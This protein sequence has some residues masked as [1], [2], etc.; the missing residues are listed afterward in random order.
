MLGRFLE[1]SI[2]TPDIRASLEF[3]AKLGFSQAEVGEAWPHPYAVVTDGRICTRS[4]PATTSQRR[5]D[6]RQTGSARTFLASSNA[7]HRFRDFAVSATTYST[8][9]VVARSF[10]PSDPAG[11]GAHLLPAKRPRRPNLAVR[12]FPR[13]RVA[14]A[15]VSRRRRTSGRISASSAW[16]SPAR[17]CRTSRCTS[18]TIDIGLYD[19]LDL[20]RPMLLFEA[21]RRPPASKRS[22][23]AA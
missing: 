1:Y 10:R 5:H 6:L 17:R 16:T 13:D 3:Y 19:P 22:S 23:K 20:P 18:D 4:A 12:L 2:A 8:K 14:R 7:R 11:R 21:E 15:A 9:L